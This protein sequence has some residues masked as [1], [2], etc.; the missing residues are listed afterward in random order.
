MALINIVDGVPV[1]EQASNS[2]TVYIEDGGEFKR[3]PKEE[4]L[5]DCA[6][7]DTISDEWNTDKSYKAGDYCIY[8]NQLWK[9]KIQNAAQRPNTQ[10]D[11]WDLV[12]VASEFSNISNRLS[13]ISSDLGDE[14]GNDYDIETLGTYVQVQGDNNYSNSLGTFMSNNTTKALYCLISLNRSGNKGVQYAIDVNGNIYTRFRVWWSNSW[15]DWTT[16]ASTM[17]ESA[18]VTK[19]KDF[20]SPADVISVKR[21]GKIVV[22][23]GYVALNNDITVADQPFLQISDSSFHPYSRNV[24]VIAQG[25]NSGKCYNLVLSGDGKL[26]FHN[27]IPSA[28]SDVFIRFNATWILP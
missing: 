23:D 2:A 16:Y 12:S 9:S 6:T 3:V 14:V 7:F 22:M 18:T 20:A 17:V 10:S 28:A 4:L 1:S 8:D 13:S 5:T 15:S 26:M 11:F 27:S 19:L 24:T 25:T 21:S